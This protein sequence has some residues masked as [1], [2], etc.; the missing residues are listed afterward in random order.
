MHSDSHRH[1]ALFVPSSLHRY[2]TT[3]TPIHHSIP[4][5]TFSFHLLSSS[6]S[7][8][9][10]F[11]LTCLFRFTSLFRLTC[12]PLPPHP[13]SS[14]SASPVIL[15]RLTC[16]P[17]PPHLL[18]SSASPD[19]LF[20]LTRYPLPPHLLSSSASPAILFRTPI[21]F[22]DTRLD[23]SFFNNFSLSLSLSLSFSL[24]LS[25]FHPF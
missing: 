14:S 22:R 15:F 2:H 4:A 3:D 11:R 23:L 25:L 17:L 21:L 1:V 7:P 5:T 13:L 18:S 9:I 24:T 8:A 16:Y 6:A 19:I 20:C 10:L 12:Y